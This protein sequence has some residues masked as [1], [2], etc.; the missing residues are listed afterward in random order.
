MFGLAECAT[1]TGVESSTQTPSGARVISA[2]K[3]TRAVK[4]TGATCARTCSNSAAARGGAG[5]SGGGSG[6]GGGGGPRSAGGGALYLNGNGEGS[7][8]EV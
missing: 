6:G 4:K 1:L 8:G 5:S 7:R 3:L 2:R